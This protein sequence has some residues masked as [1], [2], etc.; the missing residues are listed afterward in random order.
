GALRAPLPPAGLR[1]SRRAPRLKRLPTG[2][3]RPFLLPE[4]PELSLRQVVLDLQRAG[5]FD[6][7]RLLEMRPGNLRILRAHSRPEVRRGHTARLQIGILVPVLEELLLFDL[8]QQ[9]PR[10]RTGPHARQLGFPELAEQPLPAE[11]VALVRGAQAG[12]DEQRGRLQ[13]PRGAAVA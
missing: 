8:A 1:I 13:P 2:R 11:H 9:E 12:I 10:N 4:L 3:R 6:G 5:A 7:R